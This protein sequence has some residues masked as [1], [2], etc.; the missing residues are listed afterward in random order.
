MT[1]LS[2]HVGPILASLFLI[3]TPLAAQT[4]SIRGT[5]TD[6][7]TQQGLA[8]V[9]V[10]IVGTTRTTA[11]GGDGGFTLTDVPVGT[12]MVKVSRIGYGPQQR[13]VTVAAGA[14]ADEKFV[15]APQASILEPVVVTGYGSQ[16]REA[17]T[18]SVSTIEAAQ[19]NVGVKTNFTQMIQ[20][21]AAGVDIVQNNG[22]PGSGA[23]I[24]IRG[25]SS[26]SNT[27]EPLYVID[28][29]PISNDNTQPG[30]AGLG[31]PSLNRSP[32]NMLNPGDIASM[33]VLKDASATAI[34]GSRA[35]NGVVLIETKHGSTAGSTIEYDGYVAASSPAKKLDLVSPGDY[36]AFIQDQ[37]SIFNADTAAGTPPSAA[38]GLDPIHLTRLGSANTN[39]FD[40]V[41]RSA[42][43]HNHNLSFAGGSEDTRYRA[44]LNY[45]MQPG[46][47]IAN[48]LERIQGM[49]TASHHA[50]ENRLRLAATVTT[51][52]ENDKYITYEN[53]G[54][55]EGGVFMNATI[56]NP[57]QPIEV[58]DS[59][60]THYY[61]TGST[62]VRNPVALANQVQNVGSTTRTLGQANAEFDL[63][64][65][66]TAKI[67][68]GID[69]SNGDRQSYFP[70]ANPLG[71]ALGNGLAQQ[72]NLANTTR[73]LQTLLTYQRQSGD[74]S[75]DAV[76]GY[77]YTQFGNNLV[78]AQGTGFFT[79]AF[80]YNNL[81]AAQSRTDW[82][83]TRDWK[84]VSFLSRVN[85]GYKEKY[86]VTGILRYDG[87]SRFA[88]GHQ[89]A[90]FPG[91]SASWKLNSEG[92]ASGLGF[93]DLKLRVGWGRQGNPGI[94]PYQSL[95]TFNPGTGSTYPWGDTPQGGV[96]ANSNGN[97]DLKWEQTDQFNVGLDFG[98]WSNRLAGTAEYYVKNT[99]GLLEYVQA[100]APSNVSSTLQ[101]V[102][103]LKNTGFE[104]TLD[105]LAASSPSFT[106]RAGLT[107]AAPTSKVGT[108]GS[109]T[110]IRSGVV[111]GQGQ[112]DQW[113]QR[114]M[115]G[116][117]LG[118]FFGPVF[119]GIDAA[120][121]QLFRCNTP[122]ATCVNGQ[123]NAPAAGDYAV[124]GNANPDFTFGLRSSMTWSKI[125]VSF[126]VR[127]SVGGDVFNN[128]ALVYSTKGN[129]LQDKNFLASA[130]PQ[131]DATG[132][133]EPAIYSSRWVESASYVRLQNLT[134]TYTLDIPALARTARNMQLYAS[135]DNLFTITG[136]SGLDPEVSNLS[137]DPNNLSPDAGLAARGIDY[138]SYPRAR[139]VTG[140]LRISF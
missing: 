18:G 98:L 68:L 40:A 41:T 91:L 2:R 21:R 31:A 59:T 4:G 105:A 8:G 82:S 39:W 6:S 19:A 84:L 96:S 49:L 107:F 77:E 58:K 30:G 95:V 124:I 13:S 90:L 64:S 56:F 38:K 83:S 70:K 72:E 45:M 69:H 125:D 115:P 136:Y 106:W 66:L 132:L 65:S 99:S 100:P 122:S 86:F 7:V 110:F 112:S 55:F 128:T 134:V 139:T 131:N 79:D 75:F 135:V 14:T 35:S 117:P 3:A 57:T 137:T 63:N 126:L 108:L 23:Q 88:A 27:N 123:T 51:S 42:M 104:L 28:G 87:S 85:F 9:S 48:D 12:V 94:P 92:F 53:T 114:I 102:G 17:I 44:S 32:L 26:I 24:L 89:W 54:G 5:V 36:R 1:H 109:L 60:G 62:S 80:G 16:R 81:A 101:N 33:T 76:G 37:V 78:G 130:L 20:G 71:V 140:G 111:S 52:R 47:A 118:T 10:Q 34:Y 50:F 97:P 29:V 46:V 67:T 120:G 61:E 133:H 116:Q 22:E 113:S 119:L 25:G 73:T 103:K 93:S 121:K 74:K 138:L 127:G 129:A 15:M 11:T 43:T